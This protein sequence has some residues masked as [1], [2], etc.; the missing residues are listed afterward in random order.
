MKFT[1]NKAFGDWL[2]KYL[3]TN[4]PGSRFTSFCVY[5]RYGYTEEE[6]QERPFALQYVSYCLIPDALVW[7]ID[8]NE[9]QEF[10]ELAC[11]VTME[12]IEKIARGKEPL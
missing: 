9:G 5:M 8:W 1:S 7:D 10:I 4:Q 2:F 3:R 12:E 11:I 6:L